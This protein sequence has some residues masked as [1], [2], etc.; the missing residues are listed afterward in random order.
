M[1]E[2]TG[3]VVNVDGVSDIVESEVALLVARD[4][5]SLVLGRKSSENDVFVPLIVHGLPYVCKAFTAFVQGKKKSTG[6]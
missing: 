1:V 6:S 4:S 5:H 2:K 3:K